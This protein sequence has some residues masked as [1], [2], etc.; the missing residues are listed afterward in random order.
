MI[1]LLDSTGVSYEGA[2]NNDFPDE[3]YIEQKMEVGDLLVFSSMLVHR[4]GDNVTDNIRWSIQL[5]YNNL[6]DKTYIE[7]G[8]PQAYIY[9]PQDEII[10]PNFPR[11]EHLAEIFG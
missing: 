6:A 3:K 5:R 9:K 11:K 2:I 10:T 4:S 7:R 8:F 1:G